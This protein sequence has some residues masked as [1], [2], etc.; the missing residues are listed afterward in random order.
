MNCCLQKKYFEI[1]VNVIHLRRED[2]DGPLLKAALDFAWQLGYSTFIVPNA[3]D[4]TWE[5]AFK[6]EK[7][8]ADISPYGRLIMA[9]FKLK[10]M[11]HLTNATYE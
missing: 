1:R 11:M 6:R 4:R 9:E 8:Q 3:F 5:I 10:K 7:R 2:I